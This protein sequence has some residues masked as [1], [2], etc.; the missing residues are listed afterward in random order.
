MRHHAR[1]Q[2]RMHQRSADHRR[3]HEGARAQHRHGGRCREQTPRP[4]SGDAHRHR[5][6]QRCTTDEQHARRELRKRREAVHQRP[7]QRGTSQHER[8]SVA[9]LQAAGREGEQHHREPVSADDTDDQGM[10]AEP[11]ERRLHPREQAPGDHPQ[12]QVSRPGLPP[13]QP[14]P[15]DRVQRAGRHPRGQPITPHPGGP[16]GVHRRDAGER[17]DDERGRTQENGRGTERF[18]HGH[19]DLCNA[20]GVRSDSRNRRPPATGRLSSRR[21]RCRARRSC[22]SPHRGP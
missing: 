18:G 15:C 14:D 2:Q 13:P 22:R 9:T 7:G 10:P 3:R 16:V 8:P 21:C 1:G 6:Q 17:E 11:D 19:R 5:E 4:A 20:P 12:G